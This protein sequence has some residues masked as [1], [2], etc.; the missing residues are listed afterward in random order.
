[1]LEEHATT[2]Q[3]P[4][5][6]TKNHHIQVGVTKTWKEEGINNRSDKQQVKKIKLVTKRTGTEYMKE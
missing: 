1:M 3:N 4:D 5:V 2:E 6:G